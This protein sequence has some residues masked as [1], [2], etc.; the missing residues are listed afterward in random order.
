MK[1]VILNV[2]KDCSEGQINLESKAARETIANLI[3]ASIKENG[4][5][6]DL[7]SHKSNEL[8]TAGHP[9]KKI[10]KWLTRDIDEVQMIDEDTQVDHQDSNWHEWVCDICGKN[11]YNVEYDYLGSGTNHLG[12]ELE[13]EEKMKL[14]EEIVDAQKDT[15]IYESPDGG[16]TVF[17]RPFS[18]YDSEMKEE[19]DWETK[20]PTGKKF[21]QYNNGNWDVVSTQPKRIKFNDE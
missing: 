1:Q 5:Y 8:D 11:T 9:V 20:E 4:W 2:L 17:R 18:N 6:L 14:S 19:I 13:E 3:M 15:W 21:S 16:K 10:N 12:C 7:G